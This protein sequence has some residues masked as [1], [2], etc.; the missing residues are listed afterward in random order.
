MPAHLSIAVAGVLWG[1]TGIIVQLVRDTTALSPVAIG[2][3][4]L[5]I[6]AAVLLPVTAH[7]LR[8]ARAVLRTHRWSL[9]L[10]GA[11]LGAYQALYF[12]AV[13]WGGVAVAT[14]VSL[15]LAPILIAG[16]ESATARRRPSGATLAGIAAAVA[17]L[18]LI[19]GSTGPPSGAA[20]RPLLGLAA[21]L[22]SGLG[23]AVTT[24][25]SRRVS[26]RVEPLTLTTV[27]ATVGAGTLLPLAVLGG[28]VAVPV[29]S[30]A[31]GLL[32]YLG[33]V[34]TAVAYALFYRGL[35]TTTGSAAVILTLLEPL[36]AAALAVAL[37]GERVS[38]AS[39]LG[40]VLLLSAVVTASL[41]RTRA[42]NRVVPGGGVAQPV[43]MGDV[44]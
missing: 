40:G 7:L 32:V 20:P 39:A 3:H 16:W 2:F 35:R 17:G 25:L 30:A 10:I 22:A 33:V 24:V 9:L 12:L 13:A 37:L 15:G 43:R 21:A 14:V 27:S 23:Y 36:T 8:P 6:A 1:T 5:A 38:W 18:V 34:T 19:T 41:P 26:E 28:G 11:G 29:P 44:S 31:A 4:R 42:N